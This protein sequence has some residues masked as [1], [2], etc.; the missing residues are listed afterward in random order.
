MLEESLKK[1][2]ELSFKSNVTKDIKEKEKLEDDIKAIITDLK[3]QAIESFKSESDIKKFLDNIIKF[4]NYSY[5]NQ[6]LIWMQN[7]NADYVAPLRT[8]NKMGYRIKANEKG[9]K[10]LIPN[11]YTIVK[12][13]TNEE[14]KYILKPLFSLN[15]EEKEK[16]KNKDD[17]T[18]T[19]HSQKL[20]N[21]KIGSVYDASQTT[22]PLDTI[23]EKLNPVLE[24]DRAKGMEDNFIKAIYR[25][26]FKV[27]YEEKIESGAKGYCDFKNNEI[28][29]LKDLSNL[30]RLKVVI[31]EYAHSLAHK[32][33]LENN[34]DYQLHRNKY[35]TEAESIAYV[36]SKYLGLDTS[37]YSQMYLYSWSK[38][39]D[40]KEIDDSLNCIVNYSKK[41]INNY[42]KI[43]S[44]N[45]N[46]TIESFSI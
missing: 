17:N 38:D 30:M 21:F 34:K 24:D 45:I 20:S 44:K 39:K 35:E 36:V 37:S 22:M 27:R 2:N 3:K 14:G 12:I 11:F 15:D 46:E 31:H 16:Y 18:I 9:I 4:N 5:N 13:K 10:I 42:E 41:I 8:F 40:F 26:G 33:L 1:I 29:V 7:P 19:Y 32:H 43:I 25:D 28:V 6:C 23:N